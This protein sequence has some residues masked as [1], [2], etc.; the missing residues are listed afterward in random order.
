MKSSTFNFAALLQIRITSYNVC[1]TKLLRSFNGLRHIL[2]LGD[3]A[4]HLYNGL[5]GPAVQ[6]TPQRGDTG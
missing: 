2:F 5:I 1:Y 6:R 3:I 4:E